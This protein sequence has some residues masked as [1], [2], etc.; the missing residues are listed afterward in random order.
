MPE[1][2]EA[3]ADGDICE[4]AKDR[5]RRAARWLGLWTALI[6][7]VGILLLAFVA[8]TLWSAFDLPQRKIA[9]LIGFAA[10]LAQGAV[11]SWFVRRRKE[12]RDEERLAFSEVDRLCGGSADAELVRS[13]FSFFGVH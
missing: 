12:I 13:S 3:I 4:I 9:G 1:D 2:L 8:F 10:T 5:H 7:M 6:F 11:L